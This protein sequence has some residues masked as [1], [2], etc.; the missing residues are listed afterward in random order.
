MLDEMTVG[1]EEKKKGSA[2]YTG[3]VG[4][5]RAGTKRS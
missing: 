3:A 2:L 1:K 4:D 5:V